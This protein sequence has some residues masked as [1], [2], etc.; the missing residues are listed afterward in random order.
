[1]SGLSLYADARSH[2]SGE[3]PNKGCFGTLLTHFADCLSASFNFY[4]LFLKLL[5]SQ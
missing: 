5:L 3:C 2:D 1:M 4:S